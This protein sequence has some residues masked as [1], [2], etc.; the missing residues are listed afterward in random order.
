MKNQTTSSSKLILWLK[1]IGI[2]GFLFFL[3]KGLI[4]L[5]IFYW[6]AKR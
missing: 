6:A 5:A 1:R 4:W 2:G 3:I